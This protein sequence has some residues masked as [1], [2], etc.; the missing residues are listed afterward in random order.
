MKLQEF[1]I[2]A[3]CLGVLA[4]PALGIRPP[5]ILN[6]LRVQSYMFLKKTLPMF[7]VADHSASHLLLG[8]GLHSH[9]ES[10]LLIKVS[11]YT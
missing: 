8:I 4:P 3:P 9:A 2:I 1:V 5:K 10:V 7:H 6:V 11:H